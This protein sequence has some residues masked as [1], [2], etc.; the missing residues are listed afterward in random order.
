MYFCSGYTERGEDFYVGKSMTSRPLH[1][2]LTH[3]AL[4]FL[5]L[6]QTKSFT[7][8]ADLLGTSQSSI[9]RAISE[10]EDALGGVVLVDRQTRPIRMTQVGFELER[11][12][13]LYKGQLDQTLYDI[14]QNHFLHMP[15]HLGVVE[16][17]AE[18]LTQPILAS[19]KNTY[20]NALVLTAVSNRLLN[21]LDEGRVD[22]II[23]SNSFSHRNDL[24]RIFLLQEPSV[25]V[26]PKDTQLPQPLTWSSLQLCGLPQIAYDIANSGAS[27]ERRLFNEN[28]LKFVRRIEVDL[29]SL[30]M[31]MV[32]SGMGWAL[33]RVSTL[34]QY[35]QYAKQVNV[36][37][38]PDPLASREVFLIYKNQS[39]ASNALA[40][41][42]IIQAV[43]A[44][45]LIPQMLVYAPWIKPYLK[46]RGEGVL[47]RVN[48]F[49]SIEA[50][51]Q[52]MVL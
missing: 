6:C 47:E 26:A 4:C 19:L 52:A 20:S 9:S 42:K 5:A 30:L 3:Q 31:S 50:T 15:L 21:L 38:M 48:A 7:K 13:H 12:L 25:V 45:K 34:A 16:S 46:V 1:H 37:E 51:R 29:N 33:T 36:C 11:S 14:K 41:A 8:A 18:L 43:I 39:Q 40:I 27:M 35:P 17:M 2:F 23:S 22:F 28:G 24:E 32:S 44:E 10:L 49:P